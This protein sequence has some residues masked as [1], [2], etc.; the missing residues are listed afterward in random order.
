[1][2][3]LRAVPLILVVLGAAVALVI[4]YGGARWQARTERLLAEIWA[5]RVEPAIQTYDPS[6]IADL[7]APVERYFRT[8]L[9]EGQ[10]LV[11]AV[12][13]EHTGT[14]NMGEQGDQWRPFASTQHVIPRRPGFLWDARIRMAPGL[15]VFVH[16]GYVAG[17]GVLVAKLLGL[18]TVM[19]QPSTSEL[20]QGELMRFLAEGAWYPTALLP[21]QGV[22]WEPI[23]ETRARGRLT[24]GETEVD[25]VFAFDAHGLISTVR[26][27]TR[28]RE[29]EGVQVS[30][31]WEGRFWEYERRGG[32][33]VP[34]E[35][36]V[37]WL[38]PE[39]RRPY[40]R[41][42]IEAIEYEYVE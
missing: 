23:D 30:T 34:L 5:E 36:E 6:E 19:E 16:D 35:G 20:A 14:F 28:Y 10:P 2:M 39:G 15:T 38:L 24:D 31:P 3:W 12:T 18:V 11:A 26:S 9:R 37:A 21:S 25:L 13:V 22:R 7:P 8:V 17:R 1:M 29:V 42:R 4:L 32:M 40:W 33:L 27:D 41:G